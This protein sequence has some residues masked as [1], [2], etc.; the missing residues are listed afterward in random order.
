[1]NTNISHHDVQAIVEQAKDKILDKTIKKQ[2]IDSLINGMQKRLLASF[3]AAQQQNIQVL[4]H[5]TSQ[6]DRF[7]RRLCSLENKLISLENKLKTHHEVLNRVSQR[8]SQTPLPSIKPI[9][10]DQ[11]GFNRRYNFG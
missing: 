2:E 6:N 11:G 8:P 7:W 10:N 9:A 1:M 4:R 5:L 3:D